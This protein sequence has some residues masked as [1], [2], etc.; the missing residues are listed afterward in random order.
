MHLPIYLSMYLSIYPSIYLSVWTSIYLI[1]P[2][3]SPDWDVFAHLHLLS[4]DDIKKP[5]TSA[6]LPSK[7]KRSVQR[8]H[9]RANAFCDF[10]TPPIWS[11]APATENWCQ[12]IRSACTCHA[13][14]ILANLH[15]WY[16][17]MQPLSGNQR[18]DLPTSLMHMSFV[19][20][21]P[22]KNASLQIIFRCPMLASVFR[23]ATKPSWF[24]HFWQAA[25]SL[26]PATRNDIWTSKNGSYMV[27]FVHFDLEM[28]FAPQKRALFRYLNFQK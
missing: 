6:R 13:K 11:T 23:N 1:F 20:P 28:C 16:S 21:L 25:Q 19:L 10:S 9:P 4:A 18:P 26:A 17:K 7:M 3:S 24:A 27:C 12:V 2:A 14:I 15:F 22:R 8:W 5:K